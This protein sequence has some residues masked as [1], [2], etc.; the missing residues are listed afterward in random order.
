MS[1]TNPIIYGTNYFGRPWTWIRRI[2]GT[3]IFT[4]GIMQLD[5]GKEFI[6]INYFLSAL[7]IVFFLLKP[8]EDLIVTR[9]YLI[10][11]KRSVLKQLSKF[12]KYEISAM[13]NIG[14]RGFHS[15]GWELVEVFNGAGNHGGHTNTL[16]IKFNDQ[17]TKTIHIAVSKKK[18]DRIVKIVYRRI[19]RR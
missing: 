11:S 17:H 8:K 19:K 2:F 10:H 18:L 9:Q 12:T 3:I 6:F 13:E 15:D 14:C 5:F 4:I 16:L 7:L 1:N